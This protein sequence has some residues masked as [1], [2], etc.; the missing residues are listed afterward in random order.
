MKIKEE[1]LLIDR[2]EK[3]RSLE[4]LKKVIKCFVFGIIE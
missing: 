3:I 4:K 1:E 2:T